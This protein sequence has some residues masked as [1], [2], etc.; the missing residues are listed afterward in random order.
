[1]M[2]FTYRALINNI[3]KDNSIN[4]IQNTIDKQK[5]NYGIDLLRILSMINIINIHINIKTGL[6]YLNSISNPK[7]KNIIRLEAFSASAV[8]CFGLISGIVGF[9]KYKFSN[10]IY[11]WFISA[12]YSVTNKAYLFIENRINLKQLLLSFFPILIKFHWYVNSYF[13]M[14][15]F[16]PIIN[17]GIKLLNQ[18]I[19]GNLVF[20]YTLF[21]PIYYIISA[22]FGTDYNSL[23]NGFSSLWLVILYIIGSFFGKYK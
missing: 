20:F 15:L 13:I 8:D 16:L 12:F 2:G 4:T 10:L 5:R 7:F 1:M 17:F 19:L 18:K 22:L 11:L 3:L 9:H 21:F 23:L 14:Y 6:L